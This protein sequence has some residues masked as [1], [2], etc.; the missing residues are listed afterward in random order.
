MC[1][2]GWPGTLSRLGWPGAHRDFPASVFIR[3]C[4][5]MA[6]LCISG[7]NNLQEWILSCHS[8]SGDGVQVFKLAENFQPLLAEPSHCAGSVFFV[9]NRS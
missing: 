5:F 6:M 8:D 7:Q 4:V 3:V 1:I 2:P 9:F